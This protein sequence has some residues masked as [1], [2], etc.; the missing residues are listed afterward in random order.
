[1]NLEKLTIRVTKELQT[2]LPDSIPADE[3]NV[4][5]DIVRQAMKDAS[6]RTHRE[7]KGGR[8]GGTAPQP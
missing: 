5:V 8:D 4:I 7:L 6:S 1:M 3:R 2:A